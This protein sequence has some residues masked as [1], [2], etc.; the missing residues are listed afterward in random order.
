MKP[1][2]WQKPTCGLSSLTA[3]CAGKTGR[4]DDRTRPG[5]KI[6]VMFG[7]NF[8][9]HTFGLIAQISASSQ[10]LFSLRR[11]RAAEIRADYDAVIAEYR[12]TMPY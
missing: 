4:K 11:E 7:G 10:P 1:S 12:A 8:V 6:I 2:G 5:V 3:R 9:L